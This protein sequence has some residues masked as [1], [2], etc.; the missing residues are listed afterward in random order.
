MKAA[1]DAS[2]VKRAFEFALEHSKSP[3]QPKSPYKAGIAGYDNWIS[4]LETGKVGGFGNAYNAVVWNE[5]R[6]FAVQF[7]KEAKERLDNELNTLFDEAIEY[8]GTTA[9]NLEGFPRSKHQGR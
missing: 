7:L 9:V 3:P 2:T 8:Y 4:A 1:D 5:C 6:G